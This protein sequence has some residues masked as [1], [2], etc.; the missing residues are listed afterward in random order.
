VAKDGDPLRAYKY[1]L[2]VNAHTCRPLRRSLRH[3]PV[4]CCMQLLPPGASRSSFCIDHCCAGPLP[5]SFSC[6]PIAL[7]VLIF[8]AVLC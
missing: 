8:L 6:T 7:S 1:F 5:M 2:K 4:S 3:A